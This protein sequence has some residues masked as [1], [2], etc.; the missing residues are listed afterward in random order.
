M[1]RSSKAY[2][3]RSHATRYAEKY[4]AALLYR[5]SFSVAAKAFHPVAVGGH[6][7][8]PHRDSAEVIVRRHASLLLCVLSAR[9]SRSS[10]S[11]AAARSSE[12]KTAGRE[13]NLRSNRPG[14]SDRRP[15]SAPRA[16]DRDRARATNDESDRATADTALATLLPL[17]GAHLA[18]CFGCERNT[19]GGAADQPTMF[20]KS[21]ARGS[22]K[23]ERNGDPKAT[24]TDTEGAENCCIRNKGPS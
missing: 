9:I 23:A 21:C 15:G 8:I 4:R 10:T 13:A 11:N 16:G 3:R 14:A 19:T 20:A 7:G 1:A 2:P 6:M 24:F 17:S 5:P 12:L 18:D 22:Q